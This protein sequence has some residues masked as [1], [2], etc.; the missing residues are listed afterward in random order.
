VI[1]VCVDESLS[2]KPMFGQ[3][4]RNHRIVVEH[5]GLSPSAEPK[6]DKEHKSS[7]GESH[8]HKDTGHCAFVTEETSHRW[9][10]HG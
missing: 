7:R 3:S 5:A 2:P 8:D 6:Q 4:R 1:I 10:S 9:H